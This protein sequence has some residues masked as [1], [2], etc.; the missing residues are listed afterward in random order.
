[1]GLANGLEKRRVKQLEMFEF[2]EVD[3][4]VDASSK[5]SNFNDPAFASNKT[6]PI[7]RWV[8]WIAGF[9]SG[10]VKDAL[11]KY[12]KGQGTILDPFAGVGTTL[13]EA[14]AFGLNAIGFEIN[15]YPALACKAKITAHEISAEL[16][17]SEILRFQ[18]F[19]NE[20]V[21][22]SY[23]PESQPPQ[24]FKTRAEFYS[25]SVLHKVLIVQDFINF[26][27]DD[28][29]RDLFRLAFAATMVRYSNY[30]YEPSLGRR[31]SA[32]KKEIEDFPVEQIILDKLAEM[33]EDIIQFRSHLSGKV[34]KTEIIN[35]SFFN[36]QTYL[37]PESIDLII[38]SPPYLNN[39]H[40]NRNTRP[41]LYWLKYVERPQDLKALETYNFGKYW[42]TVR[43][44]KLID[45]DFSLPC[46]DIAERLQTLREINPDRGI[47][48]GNGWANYAA[49]YF[50]D[51]YRFVKG[52]NNVLKPGGRALV[53]IGNSIL[54]GILIPTDEYLG[55]IAQSIGLELVKI[56]VPRIT[57]VGNSIIQSNVRVGKA[58]DS[59]QLYE[60]VVELRK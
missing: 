47:Y 7:H 5:S 3:A 15:P 46:T 50:N 48:G 37:T 2:D 45:L 31:V 19:Y 39:Y 25:A 8:P 9:S 56:D 43:D 51:C 55:K 26:I 20:K 60:A 40:Y 44:H 23:T 59:H 49:S 58:K 10:F 32:G 6:L 1:M 53:V 33:V 54:Q 52:I 12:S 24:G 29:V 36:Y 35:D 38:T 4:K 34:A 14:V 30:S 11:N 18:N 57:R 17:C 16:F 42:Q 13:V 27:N 22:S 21:S 41:Q 28:K